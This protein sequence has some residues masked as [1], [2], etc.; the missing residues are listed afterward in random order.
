MIDTEI[1]E[2][3]EQIDPDF[4]DDFKG[5]IRLS[6]LVIIDEVNKVSEINKVLVSSNDQLNIDIEKLKTQVYNLG[7]TN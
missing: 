3:V 2:L 1:R 5:D 6:L 7:G 4:P